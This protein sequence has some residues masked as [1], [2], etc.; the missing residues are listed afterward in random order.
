MPEITCLFRWVF[1]QRFALYCRG[2]VE[3]NFKPNKTLDV[4]MTKDRSISVSS[5]MMSCSVLLKKTSSFF[6]F[7]R[8]AISPTFRRS[9]IFLKI[10]SGSTLPFAER[11]L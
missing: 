8:R 7:N 11:V 3:L 1:G 2:L 6:I 9:R 10:K 4:F 5:S